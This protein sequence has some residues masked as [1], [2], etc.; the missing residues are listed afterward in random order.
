MVPAILAPIDELPLTPNGKVDRKRLPSL[1]TI[2]PSRGGDSMP[3]RNQTEQ[4]LTEL[5][6]RVLGGERPGLRDNFFDLG[7]HSFLL[8]QLHSQLKREFD[9]NVA[10][11]ELFR[12]PTIESLASFLDRRNSSISQPV[13]AL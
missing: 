1:D 7:G 2:M 13:G 3:P 8:V 10:V 4:K 6:S 9:T 11:V 5:W 12:Y